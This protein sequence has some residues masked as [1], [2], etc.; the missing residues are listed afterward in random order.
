M[1]NI[2]DRLKKYIK[3]NRNFTSIRDFE[4]EIG[5]SYSTVNN[6]KE[7]L[8]TD[9]QIDLSKHCK[10]LNLDWLITDKG[11]ML[12]SKDNAQYVNEPINSHETLKNKNGNSFMEH[13]NG[14]FIISAPMI[15]YISYASFIE[16]YDDEK[17][18]LK[19]ETASFKVDSFGRGRYVAFTVS[20]DSMNGGGI[21]DTPNGAEVLGRELLKEHWKDGFKQTDYG[22]V[23][24]T[25]TGIMMKDIVSNIDKNGQIWLHSRNPSPEY[26]NDFP[27]NVNEIHSIWKVIKRTF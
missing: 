17:G 21:N 12:K 10:D 22:W 20:G 9:K 24:V 13:P 1:E 16:T 5:W 11:E 23:V 19:F 7:N 3:Q 25:F 18:Y 15:P 14:G 27:V 8:V 2:S 4:R 26:V 6:L